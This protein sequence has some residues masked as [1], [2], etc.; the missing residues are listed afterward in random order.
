PPF[1]RTFFLFL[2]SIRLRFR[3]WNR[4][5]SASFGIFGL[6]GTLAIARFTT[7]AFIAR[8]VSISASPVSTIRSLGGHLDTFGQWRLVHFTFHQLLNCRKAPTIAAIHERDGGAGGLGTRRPANP[9]DVIF[10][11]GW[12]II[13]NH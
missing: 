4:N 3:S 6:L 1:E 5:R 11:I 7:F 10:R 8:P 9:V 2:G 12:H 13:V